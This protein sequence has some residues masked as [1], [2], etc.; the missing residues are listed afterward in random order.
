MRDV[1]RRERLA[2]LKRVSKREDRSRASAAEKPASKSS[3]DR[4]LPLRSSTSQSSSSEPTSD[5]IRP[6]PRHST[7]QVTPTPTPMVP[8]AWFVDPFCTLPGANELPSMT[9]NLVHYCITVFIPMTFPART[10][11]FMDEGDKLNVMVKTSLTDAG[12]F[13]GL[14]TISAAHRAALTG[15]HSDLLHASD[16]DTRVLYDP[17]Y[18]LMKARCIREMNEK[19]RDPS[20]ALSHE[21][22][23][24]IINLLTSALIVGLFDE[25]RI[26]L[27]GLK[28]MV[29]LRGGITSDNIRNSI[30]MPAILA[31]DLKTATGL[32]TKPVFPLPWEPEPLAPEVRQRICPPP[33]SKLNNLGIS[34][35]GNPNFSLPLV[36]ALYGMRDAVLLQHLGNQS[37][38]GLDISDYQLLL[39]M[40]SEVEHELLSYPYRPSTGSN[41]GSGGSNVHVTE[42]LARVA[43]I[44]SLNSVIIVSPSSTGLGRAL[45]KHLKQAIS[46]F[47]S[48]S[49]LTQMPS[50]DLDLLA[51]ALFIAAQGSLGQIEQPWFVDRLADVIALRGWKDWEEVAEIM[52]RYFYLPYL[53]DPVWRPIWNE[54]M[55]HFAVAEVFTG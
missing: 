9:Q 14:M 7:S 25:A 10:K 15:R 45:T 31:S 33:S 12:S 24:T 18:Y 26:H 35:L 38:N 51:W 48:T 19:L 13:F 29:E 21:A 2:G 42:P 5:L 3:N 4:K 53:H 32:M 11:S 47:I 49:G 20:K 27:R 1:R 39:K 50:P 52:T 6:K 43:A 23:D 30:F 37:P 41:P 16:S 28:K 44:C 36:R 54:A 34:L 17:D 22:F 8:N 55:A 46:S 40:T